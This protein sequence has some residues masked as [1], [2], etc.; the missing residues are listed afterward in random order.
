MQSLD[1][2]SDE[3]S[4]PINANCVV[5]VQ[6]MLIHIEAASASG[7]YPVLERPVPVAVLGYSRDEFLCE[8]VDFSSRRN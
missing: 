4:K 3:A 1:G 7:R 2:P 5:P 6:I 8:V